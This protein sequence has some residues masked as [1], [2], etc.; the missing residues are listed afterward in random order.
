MSWE[1]WVLIFL[2]VYA[3]GDI[4]ASV[5]TAYFAKKVVVKEIEAEEAERGEIGGL[6]DG[7][8]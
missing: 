5:Y 8:E 1:E 3:V 7:K 2:A 6:P 4:C